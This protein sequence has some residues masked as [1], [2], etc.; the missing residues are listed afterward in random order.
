[1]FDLDRDQRPSRLEALAG[2]ILDPSTFRRSFPAIWQVLD[3]DR[4]DRLDLDEL[5]RAASS[6]SGTAWQ[7]SVS[8]RRQAA[9]GP[10]GTGFSVG[11]VASVA[12][13][14]QQAY[15]RDYDIVGGQYDPIVGVV[16]TGTVLEISDVLVTIVRRR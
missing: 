6:A 4:N 3:R 16:S 8:R 5:D 10:I 13:L 7:L 2:L 15:I 14:S 12:F 9:P 1:M 11:G